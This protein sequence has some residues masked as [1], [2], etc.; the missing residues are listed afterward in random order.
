MCPSGR[1][2]KQSLDE[3]VLLSDIFPAYSSDLTLTKDIDRFITLDGSPRR[4]EFTESLL[5]VHAPFDRSVVLL[6]HPN[7]SLVNAPGLVGR[8]EMTPLALLHFR[9]VPLNPAPH[10]RVIGAQAT[11]LEEF[12]NVSQ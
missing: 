10:R 12:L 7:I 5:G 8:F 1:E 11:F 4:L 2:I 9:G 3:S 6:L